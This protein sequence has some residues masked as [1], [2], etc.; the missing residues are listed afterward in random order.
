MK[1]KIKSYMFIMP[2]ILVMLLMSIL[3]LMFGMIY[4]DKVKKGFEYLTLGLTIVVV[5]LVVVTL[6]QTVYCILNVYKNE[7]FSHN[8]KLKWYL[9]LFFLNIIIMPYYY[10]KHIK[11]VTNY[12]KKSII[13]FII[14]LLFGIVSVGT[15]IYSTILY[16]N[17]IEKQK[18]IERQKNEIRNIIPSNDNKFEA[19]FKI[20]FKKSTVSDYDL[21]VKDSER[22]IITGMFFYDI[23]NF[24]EK[25]NDAVLDKQAEYI[26][27]TRKNVKVYKEKSVRT[28][29]NKTISTIELSGKL[30]DTSE[31]IYKLSTISFEGN[32]TN[33]IYV[34]QVLIKKD[35]SKYNDEL[36]EIV[37][38]INLK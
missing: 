4:V 12:K 14:V 34:V 32:K 24:A 16:N 19:S 29:N 21:Y 28:H 23:T 22:N 25:T 27:N 3:P 1:E 11:E 18:E 35:Y 15:S 26:K 38:S 20:G 17:H 13:Y 33:I 6:I 2:S 7:K 31:C 36:I 5:F 10:L 30:D 37:D 8:D 9:L